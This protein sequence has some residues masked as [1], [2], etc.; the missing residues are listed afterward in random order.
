[1]KGMLSPISF[2]LTPLTLIRSTAAPVESIH[3]SRLT[4]VLEKLPQNH[5]ASCHSTVEICSDNTMS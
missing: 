2:Q 4:E 1:M 3:T 5:G